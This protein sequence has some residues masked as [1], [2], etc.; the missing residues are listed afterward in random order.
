M[1][2]YE[3]NVK[4]QTENCIAWIKDWFKNK[5]SDAKVILGISGGIDSTTTGKLCVEALGADKVIG[6]RLPCG[7]QKDIDDAK[8]ACD[9]LGIK[10]Y[11]INIGETYDMLTKQ[12]RTVVTNGKVFPPDAYSTN[13]PARI[14]MTTIYGV[15]AIIG[16]AYPANTCN[17]SETSQGYDTIF[18]D[19]AGSFAPIGHFTK[20]EVRAIAKYLGLP[21]RLYNKTPIDGMSVNEDGSYKADEDKLGFTYEELDSFLRIGTAGPNNEKIINGM[22]QSGWKRKLINVEYYDPHLPFYASGLW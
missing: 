21:E 4:E 3:F 19:S 2:G 1:E 17:L 20:T 18:G 6:L 22:K 12:M 8:L 16:N 9:E 14:R 7:E 13:T 11:E 15:A 5:G 10:S